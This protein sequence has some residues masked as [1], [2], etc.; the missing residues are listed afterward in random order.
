MFIY[1]FSGK[2]LPERTVVNLGP[3]PNIFV[4]QQD[5]NIEGN[6]T[7][8]IQ[9]SIISIQFETEKEISD[10]LTLRA[11]ILR[12]VQF[13]V[14]ILG[15]ELSCGYRIEITQLNYP[16]HIVFGVGENLSEKSQETINSNFIKIINTFLTE[17]N[18]D[19]ERNYLMLILA[20]IR[21]AILQT[22]M[23]PFHCFRAIESIKKF[24]GAKYDIKKDDK[25]WEK[26]REELN[27]EKRIIDEVK[28]FADPIRHG[29]IGQVMSWEKRKDIFLTTQQIINQFIEWNK[30]Q[31]RNVTS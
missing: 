9:C 10:Y 7:F 1:I 31:P 18:R 13:H 23:T 16:E 28:K 20:D 26:L 4:K 29:D 12:V 14:D 6:L 21:E 22:H 24:F 17:N 30:S 19:L 27:V 2:V 25:Q 5:V 15:Y 3:F 11:Y 8:S